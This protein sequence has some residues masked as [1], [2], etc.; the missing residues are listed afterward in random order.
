[1][2]ASRDLLELC[3]IG[4]VFFFLYIISSLYLIDNCHVVLQTTVFVE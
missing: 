2:K 1:M 4:D 3:M